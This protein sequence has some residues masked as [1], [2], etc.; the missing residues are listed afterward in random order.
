MD[1]KITTT[2]RWAIWLVL[3]GL[4]ASLPGA[5]ASG[6]PVQTYI[7]QGDSAEQ[8]AALVESAG[9]TV[10]SQ[11]DI[12]HGVAAQLT[13]EAASRLKRAAGIRGLTSN[14]VVE[15]VGSGDEGKNPGQG[16]DIPASDYPDVT[17]ADLVW[18]AG[19]TGENV[20]VA[21]VDTGIARMPGLE[22]APD[23]KHS[24][25]TGWVDLVEGK[26][27]PVDPNG[28]GTH[29]AGVI[30]NSQTGADQ[31]W[32][33]MAP[34]I[35]LVG[36]RVLDEHGMGTYENVIRGIEWVIENRETYNIRVM[37]LSLIALVQSPYWADPLNQA[38]M[39]AWAEGITVVAAAGN[40]GPAAAHHRGPGE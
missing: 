35:D 10:T 9:G 22:N 5:A 2:R 14:G 26:H 13:P 8:V 40:G 18:A 3:F 38:I 12:I 24:R 39:R 32:N 1:A 16:P 28:H 33:G 20:G 31:E 21:V 15:V 11:L 19:T 34:G 6:H 7:L 25:I 17:G 29:V 30:A 36:V 37:N 23:G 4:I 27:K